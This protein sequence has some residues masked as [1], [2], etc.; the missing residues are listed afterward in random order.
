M[1]RYHPF[2]IN[3]HFN[4]PREVTAETERA[5]SLLADA[6]IPLGNQTVL[7][8]GVN[9]DTEIMK[10][11]MKKLLAIRVKPYYIYQADLVFGTDHFRTSVEK[12]LEIVS[13]LRGHISGLGVPHYVI[14]APNGGG[15]IAVSPDPVIT[16][17]EKEITLRNYEGNLYTYPSSPTC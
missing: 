11:L 2:Y 17:D 1:K 15:K 13:A 9:D 3:T 10:E 7:L 4:H 14:D 16:F 6:G 5:C 12:G 8:R